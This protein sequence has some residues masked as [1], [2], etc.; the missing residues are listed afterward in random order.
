MQ[1][2][3]K[4]WL[5][6]VVLAVA[7]AGGGYAWW[8]L[9]PAP[10]PPGIAM[11]NGR[12]EATQIEVATKLPGRV[13]EVFVREGDFA[14]EGQVVAR[15]DTATLDAELRQADAQLAQAKNGV[16]TANAVVAQRESE[17]QL[18]QN[19][20]KR[21]EELVARGFISAQKLDADRATTLSA[22]HPFEDLG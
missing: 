19:T 20:L 7:A 17:F 12:V 3:T 21:S 11:S 14:A 9:Q 10:L 22:R 6:V 15:M 1:Q 4:R 2:Q 16:A 8:R 5:A 13:S 18:A